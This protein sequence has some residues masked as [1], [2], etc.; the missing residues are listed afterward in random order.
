VKVSRRRRV[1]LAA[2]GLSLLRPA[3][4]RAAEPAPGQAPPAVAVNVTSTSQAGWNASADR[5]DLFQRLNLAS[6]AGPWYAGARFDAAVFSAAAPASGVSNRYTLEKATLAHAGRALELT[7][8]DLYLSLG[9]GLSLSL[10]KVDELG[11]D[12]TLRGARVLVHLARFEGTVAAGYVNINNVDEA[13]GKSV[14]EPYDLVAAAHAR[15]SVSEGVTLAMSSTAIAFRDGVGLVPGAD[16]QDRFLHLGPAVDAPRL[17]S[18]LGL[19]L[20]GLAQLRQTAQPSDARRGY[21]LYGAATLYLP[22][23]TVLIEGKAYGDLAPVKPRLD[24]PEF[25]SVAYSSPPTAERL[26]QV[27]ENPQREIAGARVSV[28]WTARPGLAWQANY[29]LFRDWQ[30]YSDPAVVGAVRPAVIHDPYLG[31]EARSGDG[32]SW[33]LASLGWRAVLLDHGG[34]LVRGDAHA[35]LDAARVLWGPWSL[36][37]QARHEERRKHESPILDERHRE[38]TAALG[39]RVSPWGSAAVA[40]EYT[41]ESTQ[42]RQH[43]WN[44]SLAWNI[45]SDSSLRL[46]VGGTRGGL[47]CISGVCR[48]FPSFQG[49]RATATLRF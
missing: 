9:R 24:R 41:T 39:L 31:V 44:G 23:V 38:G 33:L 37:L 4:A 7:A 2:L 36:T 25:G 16:Y 14:G 22:A 42:P 6:E 26:L 45:T 46:L 35:E 3:P 5:G 20:E 49:V 17:T 8:G 29:G 18:W 32:R 21:G 10:R 27:L 47:R 15:V 19:Y 48:V 43:H 12:S 28:D 13:S 11:V 40:Y 30:G 34:A 1:A